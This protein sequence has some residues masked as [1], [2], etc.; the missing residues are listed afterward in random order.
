MEVPSQR[1]NEALKLTK[2]PSAP[3]ADSPAQA[4]LQLNLGVMPHRALGFKPSGS[5]CARLPTATLHVTL[6]HGDHAL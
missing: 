2:R 6:L 3:R 4:A 5:D 1:S